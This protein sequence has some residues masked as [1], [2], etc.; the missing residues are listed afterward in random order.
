MADSTLLYTAVYDSM[1]D[2]RA[3]LDAFE[4]VHDADYLG[5]YDAAVVDKKNGKPHI[6][7]RVDRPRI[8]IIPE[9]FG[10]GN[11]PR[12]EL[13]A[14]A[15][16]LNASNVALIVVGEPTLEKGLEQTITRAARTAKHDVDV[17]TDTL[18]D[19]LIA[20]VRD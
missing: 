9:F 19:E 1:D 5:K 7:K 11:L 3:D 20:A 13:K 17:A 18:A 2:A 6:A 16:E 14:A 12:K 15:D 4:A 10:A 8:E